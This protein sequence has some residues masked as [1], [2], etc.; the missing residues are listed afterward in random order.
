[1]K[2]RSASPGAMN[3]LIAPIA[4][5]RDAV[6]TKYGDL[7][8]VLKLAGADPECME[9]TAVEQISQRYE[10]AMR[11]LGTGYRM[12]QYVFKRS[13][14][15]LPNGSVGRL[16]SSRSQWLEARRAELFSVDLFLVLLRQRPLKQKMAG[17][18][19]SLSVK[20]YLAVE[21]G[22]LQREYEFLSTHASSIEQYLESVIHPVRLGK[23]ETLGFLRR[24]A[25]VTDWKAPVYGDVQDSHL[26][27]QIACSSLDAHRD[28]LRQD[29]YFL[30]YMAMAELP[31]HT[32][33]YLLRGLLN[34]DCNMTIC[35]EWQRL[36]NDKVHATIDKKRRHYH[37]AKTSMLSFFSTSQPQPHEVL[38]DDSKG[39][40]V[41]TLND[42]LT[43]IE[44]NERHF[45]KCAI[46]VGIYHEA[47]PHVR[48]SCAKIA[49]VFG[50]YDSKVVEEDWNMVDCWR[51]MIPGN[52]EAS[53]RQSYLLNTCYADL[54][55]LF[56]PASGQRRNEH[57]NGPALA[58]LETKERT[59]YYL[60]LHVGDVGHTAILGSIGSGKSFLTN[61]LVSCYQE[62]KPYTA[63]FDLGGSYRRLTAEYGGGYLH[64]G[65][66]NEFTINPF[67][68]PLN[69]ENLGFLFAFVQVLIEQDSY[70]MSAEERKDLHRTIKDMYM[71]DA[72][73]RRLETLARTCARS[74]APRLQEWVGR[75]RLSGYFD[76]VED[77]LTFQ[78]FQA[79]DFEG[80][81]D[82]A[83]VLQPMLFYILHRANTIIYDPSKH[84][85]PKLVVFDEAWRFFSN[86][87]TQAYIREA[88]KTWRKRNGVMILATQSGD[89]L[90][91]SGLLEVVSESCMTR[92]FLANPGMDATKY[93]E[94]FQINKTESEWIKKLVPKSQFLLKQPTGSK[95]LSL[96]TDPES[97]RIFSN[98]KENAA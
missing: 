87:V 54:S 89:D 43:E 68:L 65:K 61:F 5:F 64:I 4:F 57:L 67:C 16:A 47:L 80:L 73:D 36:A 71:L 20:K 95:I 7:F 59:P 62:Y 56:C 50:S 48:Q 10:S 46:T 31:S 41:K 52:Y 51:L 88:L 40:I 83:D 79:F 97:Y 29:E 58:I 30:K 74:Y 53:R 25:N 66:Q 86:P 21:Q 44:V 94:A 85:V 15:A 6:L 93:E 9:P 75:G 55:F 34:I 28:Y 27:Q 18:M 84:E 90:M 70:S 14:P 42:A 49:E 63:I 3:S 82:R 81:S 23:S 77:T 96:F 22:A 35:T 33:P 19:E 91:R 12:Y 69:E 38:I 39:A 78:R 17:F 76:N 24:L 37:L 1:M 45:G 60:N 2:D 13:K 26:D 32:A 92:L 8:I 98:A 11:T 72:S